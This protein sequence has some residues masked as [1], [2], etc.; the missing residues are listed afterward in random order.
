MIW[1][2]AEIEA[3]ARGLAPRSWEVMDGY[4]AEMLRKYKGENAGYDPEAFKD[5]ASMAHARAALSAL[6]PTLIALAEAA[7]GCNDSNDAIWARDLDNAAMN[8]A[9]RNAP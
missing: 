7:D 9:N 8:Y 1:S 4:L 5:K 6:P 2:D 3:V